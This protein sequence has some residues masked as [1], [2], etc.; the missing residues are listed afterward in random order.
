[1]DR[2]VVVKLTPAQANAVISCIAFATAGEWEETFDSAAA[3]GSARRSFKKIHE[4][5]RIM[6]PEEY[7]RRFPNAR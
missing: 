7:A 2:D 3:F 6:A 5:F 1:M 4:A